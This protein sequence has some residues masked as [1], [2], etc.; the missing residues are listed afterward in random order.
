[1]NTK[2]YLALSFGICCLSVTG[3]AQSTSKPEKPKP[4]HFAAVAYLPRG[5]ART[6]SH[7]DIRIKGYSTD[8]ETQQL[9]ATL[10]DRGQ[11]A[12]MKALEKMKEIGSINLS[13]RVGFYDF[14][15]V[16]SRPTETGRRIVAVTDRPFGFLE[17]YYSGRSKDYDLGILI[18]DVKKD[19]KG[20]EVGEGTLFYA[21]KV[22]IVNGNQVEIEHYGID[23]IRLANLRKY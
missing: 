12:L 4:E 17:S 8:A 11:D 14:K 18:L 16:R 2:R 13:S 6:A 21:A 22:K 19:K 9:A 7:V 15:L 10:I 20:K 3:F 23:P 5:A 1:M